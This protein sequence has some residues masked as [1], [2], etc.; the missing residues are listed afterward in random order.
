MAIKDYVVNTISDLQGVIKDIHRSPD[1]RLGDILVEERLISR[2][3]LNEALVRQRRIDLV[4]VD[5]LHV[6]QDLAEVL[7]AFAVALAHQ[8]FDQQFAADEPFFDQD[9]AEPQVGR[10]VE[11]LDYP[12]QI[13]DGVHYVVFDCHVT[14]LV[15]YA[16]SLDRRRS[17]LAPVKMFNAPRPWPARYCPACRRRLSFTVANSLTATTVIQRIAL[18]VKHLNLNSIA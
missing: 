12:L 14:P 9:V 10:A 17:G 11:V 3:Q 18:I 15:F 6:D 1:L 2:E 7:D 13:A 4:L 5:Q 8:C 16:C